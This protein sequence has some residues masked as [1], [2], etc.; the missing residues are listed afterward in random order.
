[1][2]VK[3]LGYDPMYKCLILVGKFYTEALHA[4][5]VEV[6]VETSTAAWKAPFFGD[7][8]T[9]IAEL[10]ICLPILSLIF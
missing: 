8:N 5:P 9:D 3:F 10:N 7:E 6:C 4:S 1:M 2:Y